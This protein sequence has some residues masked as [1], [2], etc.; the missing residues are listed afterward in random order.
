LAVSFE[1]RSDGEYTLVQ[2]NIDG[3]P[4]ADFKISIEGHHDLTNANFNL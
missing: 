2:G 4:G 3:G 1:T